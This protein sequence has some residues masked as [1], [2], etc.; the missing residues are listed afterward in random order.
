[1]SNRFVSAIASLLLAGGL[2]G[3]TGPVLAAD[4]HET[5]QPERMP[6]SFAGPFGT[7]DR[8]QIQRGFKVYHEVCASC[9]SL[10]L[11]SFRNLGQPGALGYSSAQVAAIAAEAKVQD[12]NDAGEAIER[13]GRPS[14]RF[15]HP[16]PNEATARA[17]NGGALPP[18]LSLIAKART[19]ESGFPRFLLDAVTQYQQQGPDYIHAVLTGYRDATPEQ[20]AA[21]PGLHF[22]LF[23]PGNWIAMPKPISDGQVEYPDGSPTTVEQYSKDVSAFLMWAAEPHLEA[24]KRIGLQVMIFLIVLAG[25]LYYTKKKIWHGDSQHA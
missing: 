15:P 25:L 9:H 17:A 22:N 19:F 3:A 7:F 6:W 12:I 18:D 1:M 23:F 14:D 2:L 13:P 11:V 4:G 20:Q 10:N 8:A 21:K 16:F 5:A 24:R